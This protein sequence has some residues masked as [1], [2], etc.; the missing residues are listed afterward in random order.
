MLPLGNLSGEVH[1]WRR[2]KKESDLK[3]RLERYRQIKLTHSRPEDGQRIS[4]PVW[5]VSEDEKLYLLPV[6][7]SDTQWYRNMLKNPSIRVDAR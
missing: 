7:S 4:N 5:F 6:H 3:E 2:G 1:P